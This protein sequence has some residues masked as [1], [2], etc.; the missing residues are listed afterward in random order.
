[1]APNREYPEYKEEEL[2]YGEEEYYQEQSTKARGRGGAYHKG[3][4]KDYSQSRQHSYDEELD[5]YHGT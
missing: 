1:M 3:Y 4:C 2:Y 5:E